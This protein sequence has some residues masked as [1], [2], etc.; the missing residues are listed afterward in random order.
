MRA[1]AGE[2]RMTMSRGTVQFELCDDVC[3]LTMVE[4]KLEEFGELN[5]LSPKLMFELNL[6]LEELI[7]NIISHG[8]ADKE[9]PKHIS[10]VLGMEDDTL[11]IAIEDNGVPFDPCRCEV[12]DTGLPPDER[13]IGGLGVH[14]TRK[15]IDDMSYERRGDRNLLLLRKKLSGG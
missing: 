11:T 10:V 1:T 8:F 12:A 9:G 15:V 3:E 4:Q 13:E 14:L 6:A 5:G 7:V 2:G